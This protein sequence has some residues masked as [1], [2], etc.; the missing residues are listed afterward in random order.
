ML[1]Q[2]AALLTFTGGHLQHFYLH[3]CVV[4]L[5]T[6]EEERKIEAR[7]FWEWERGVRSEENV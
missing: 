2:A 7:K 1:L 5:E 6:E 3:S 4:N